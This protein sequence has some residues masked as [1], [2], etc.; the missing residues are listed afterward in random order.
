MKIKQAEYI[1][2]Y[3]NVASCPSGQINLN[4]LLSVA[5]Q[6]RQVIS[7]INMLTNKKGSGKGLCNS[8]E[9]PNAQFF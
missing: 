8:W 3:P 9:N 4:L 7:L 5:F 1:A 2:S 6:C